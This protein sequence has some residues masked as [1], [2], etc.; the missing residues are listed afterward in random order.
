MA[1]WSE[2]QPLPSSRRLSKKGVRDLLAADPGAPDADV[3]DLILGEARQFSD[4]SVLKLDV[5]GRGILY[6]SRTQLLAALAAMKK[7][8]GSGHL[9][10]GLLP[11]GEEFPSH[12]S[13]LAEEFAHQ[14]GFP[15]AF[16]E[17]SLDGLDALVR[18]KRLCTFLNPTNFPRLLAY[19][20]EIVRHTVRGEWKMALDEECGI[21]E[22]WIIAERGI[23]YPAFI[24]A[25]ELAEWGR[26]RG[27]IEACVGMD[28]RAMLA[29]LENGRKWYQLWKFPRA[30]R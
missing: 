22:P 5:D 10:E 26:D 24:F 19:V 20:G 13:R 12:V 7:Q 30:R 6:E 14:F 27:S 17:K 15:L 25:L 3:S 29:T 28:L 18:R 8:F 23:H 1:W 4:G 2:P 16:E 21:W 9:L 11:Q